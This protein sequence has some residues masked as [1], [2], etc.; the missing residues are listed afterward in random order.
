MDP[1][2]KARQGLAL[3]KDAIIDVLR[4]APNGLTNAQ[5]VN[6]LGLDSDY[7]GKQRNYLSWSVLGVLLGE[8][9]IA[10]RG[11]GQKRCYLLT[12]DR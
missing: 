1:Q 9:K 6:L 2:E 7:E 4:A 12:G 8:G 5:I 3:I 10:R 11:D